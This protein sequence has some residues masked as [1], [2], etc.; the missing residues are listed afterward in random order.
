MNGEGNQ[1]N[2]QVLREVLALTKDN[3]KILRSMRR[4]AVIGGILKTLLWLIAIFAPLY[5]YY[6]YIAPQLAPYFGGSIPTGEDFRNL[7][8]Q[9]QEASQ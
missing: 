5:L 2:D 3:N 6:V 1:T 9:Y 4:N 7:L 8:N